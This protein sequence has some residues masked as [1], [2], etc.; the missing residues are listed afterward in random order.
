MNAYTANGWTPVS[1]AA[2]NG[3]TECV[4]LLIKA[5]ADVNA[6]FDGTSTTLMAASENGSD[7]CIDMLLK[8]GADVNEVSSAGQ[9]ALINAA[10]NGSEA[11][12]DLLV[13]AGADVNEVNNKGDTALIQAAHKGHDACVRLLI[14]SGADLNVTTSHDEGIMGEVYRKDFAKN[15]VSTTT[16]IG[17]TALFYAALKGHAKCV[18]FLLQA[19]ADVNIIYG[20]GYTILFAAVEARRVSCLRLVLTAGAPVNYINCVG[21]NTLQYCIAEFIPPEEKIASLLLTSG[22]KLS[23]STFERFGTL[24]RHRHFS[25]TCA[26]IPEY[27][28]TSRFTIT[29]S[30]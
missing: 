17:P 16:P 21:Q 11:S 22:E 30:G 12:I 18:D 3:H 6:Y 15:V 29:E 24:R 10:S 25:G 27:L 19:G 28:E 5:G 7:Q 26:E 4:Q 9:T 20:D 13:R 8:A 14:R 1:A 23:G 2:R